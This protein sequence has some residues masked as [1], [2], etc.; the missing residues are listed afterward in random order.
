[1]LWLVAGPLRLR[2][3]RAPEPLSPGAD[4]NPARC[5]VSLNECSDT[6]PSA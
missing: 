1:V 3:A 5:A 2:Y 6:G 4:H